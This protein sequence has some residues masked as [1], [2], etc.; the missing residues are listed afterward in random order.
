MDLKGMTPDGTGRGQ[1]SLG[2][3]GFCAREKRRMDSPRPA[4]T[5]GTAVCRCPMAEQ[6]AQHV[7]ECKMVP[8][9]TALHQSPPT[10]VRRFSSC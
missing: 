8:V 9:A 2:V 5:L 3:Q 4:A 6:K 10:V 1:T 7:K